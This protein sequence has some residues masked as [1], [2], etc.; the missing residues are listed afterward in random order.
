MIIKKKI[1]TLITKLAITLSVR[2]CRQGANGRD[3]FLLLPFLFLHNSFLHKFPP[4]RILLGTIAKEPPVAFSSSCLT[5]FITRIFSRGWND[6]M[7]FTVELPLISLIFGDLRTLAAAS[8]SASIWSSREACWFM[9]LSLGGVEAVV[10][11]VIIVSV[12]LAMTL[13]K[14]AASLGAAN[15]FNCL[16]R[17]RIVSWHSANFSEAVV[18]SQSWTIDQQPL[19]QNQVRCVKCN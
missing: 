14:R 5:P 9:L 8:S 18:I 13:S 6:P 3:V 15:A 19:T 11:V 16:P 10:V 12:G 7:S 17:F 1:W 4:P 2:W